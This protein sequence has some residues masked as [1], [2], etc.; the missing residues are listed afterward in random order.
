MI[1]EKETYIPRSAVV[2]RAGDTA[3]IN[4]PRVVVGNMPWS[5][6]PTLAAQREKEGPAARDVERL[7]RSQSPTSMMS[8]RVDVHPGGAVIPPSP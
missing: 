5:E 4:V 2:R 1:F 6:P 8:A 3:F 7:Y